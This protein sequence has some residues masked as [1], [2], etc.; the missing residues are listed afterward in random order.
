[1]KARSRK[2]G[3]LGEIVF[4]L[5]ISVAAAA[6]ALTL[7]FV[8]PGAF[9]ARL[10]IAGL[11]LAVVVRSIARSEEKTGR[12]VTLVVW[13][14]AAAA[15]WLS[16]AGLPTFVV[17]HAALAWLVRSLFAY[18]RLIDAGVDLGLTVLAVCFA[19]FAAVRT[20]SVFLAAWCFLLV[21]ALHV[22]IP[23]LVSSWTGAREK[24]LPAGDPNR[25]F[26]DAFKAADEALHRIAGHR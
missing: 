3:F 18:S 9:V 7:S 4:G 15:I 17:V 24:E 12:I 11:G 1:M 25:G 22:A 19:I 13:I 10:I 23:G 20:E 21:Q 26:A 8:L 5:V 6:L 16:G 14:V 2:L